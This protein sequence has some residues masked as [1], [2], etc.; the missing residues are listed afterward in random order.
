MPLT[1]EGVQVDA[2]LGLVLGRGGEAVK[3]LG[4]DVELAFGPVA[5]S[6]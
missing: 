6:G 4:E 5:A 2:S 1:G 3:I